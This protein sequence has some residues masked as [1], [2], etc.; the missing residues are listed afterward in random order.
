[1]GR[2]V[3]N[4]D[5]VFGYPHL[6]TVPSHV[7]YNYRF[8]SLQTCLF[9]D[10]LHIFTL[11]QRAAMANFTQQSV[12][13]EIKASPTADHTINEEKHHQ[14]DADGALKYALSDAISIDDKTNKRLLWM[15]DSHVL[16]WLCALYFMQYLDKGILSYS[17]VMGILTDAHLTTSQFTWLGSIYYFGYLAAA[18][19]HNRLL[20]HFS[21]TKYIAVCSVLWGVVLCTMAAGHNFAGLMAV[22]GMLI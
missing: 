12:I 20:Q 6:E 11:P 17:S 16:P 9:C 21:Q 18:Y 2:K 4:I 3:A 10:H 1:M 22:R 15:I 7:I 13:E 19:P 5:T 14:A 8:V